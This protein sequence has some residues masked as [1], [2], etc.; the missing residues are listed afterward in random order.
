MAGV[1]GAAVGAVLG[2]ISNPR[3]LA[4]VMAVFAWAAVGGVAGKI[5]WEEIGE[6]GDEVAG[7]LEGGIASATWLFFACRNKEESL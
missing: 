2:R 6:L 4:L 5:P 7:G 3:L 1:V